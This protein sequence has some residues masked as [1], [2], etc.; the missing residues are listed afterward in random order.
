[1]ET[2]HLKQ[3][4]KTY[5]ELEKNIEDFFNDY[6]PHIDNVVSPRLFRISIGV[7]K[8][9]LSYWKT[10]ENRRKWFDLIKTYEDLLLA[11]IEQRTIDLAESSERVNI[12]GLLNTLRAYDTELYAP[13]YRINKTDEE[14]HTPIKISFNNESKH[15]LPVLEAKIKEQ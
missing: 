3:P 2:K 8:A 11:F 4:P 13:E 15:K 10:S 12:V 5:E 9:T 14:A 6:K 1:M 7:S